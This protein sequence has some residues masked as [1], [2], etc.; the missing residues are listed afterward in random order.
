MSSLPESLM[1]FR[2]ELENAI[3]LE[4]ARQRKG[5]RRR[6]LLAVA[7]AGLVV[8][9]ASASAFGTVRDFFFGA[10]RSVES[11]AP[12]WSPD[13]RRIAFVSTTCAP[14]RSGCAGPSEIVVVGLDGSTQ[15]KLSQEPVRTGLGSPPVL[16]PNWRKIAFVR[17]RGLYRKY[18][19]G[20][21]LHYSDIV[22]MNVDG[23][24][25]RLL[26]RR[27]F[28]SDPVWSPDGNKVAFVRSRGNNTEVYVANADGSGRR[29]LAHAVS[30]VPNPYGVNKGR[31]PSPAWSPDGQ[32]I[33]FMSNRG[34]NED[35][36]VVNVDGAGMVNV[37]QSRGTD[38]TPVWSPDGRRIAFRSDRDGNGEVYA[39]NADGSG[40]QRLTRNP[41]SDGGPVWSPDGRKILFERFRH[42]NSDI[43]VMNRDGSGQRNLTP[44]VRP[45]RIA[46][47]SSPAWSPAGRLIAFVSERD[48]TRKVYVMT[49]AGGES[50]ALGEFVD[51][52][53]PVG[54][55]SRSAGDVRFSLSVPKTSPL[56][57]NG[58]L[59]PRFLARSFLIRRSLVRGQAA[60]VMIY[61]TALPGGRQVAPC[62]Q[63]LSPA[64]ARSSI[65]DLAATLAK[66]PGSELVEAPTRVT[67]GG[68]PARYVELVVREDRGCNPGFFFT[69]RDQ[70]WGALWGGTEPGDR[71]RAWIVGVDGRR[72]FFVAETKEGFNHPLRPPPSKSD[73]QRVGREITKIVESIRFE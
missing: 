10:R 22:V 50:G 5:R 63:L 40:L 56:W 13:G 52:F 2:T 30:Y 61:W 73:L 17:D 55:I 44:D 46:R 15:R 16:S 60:E 70:M 59:G 32:R 11:G 8:T 62:S 54:R 53:F 1:Q 69:W 29:R 19:D 65:D 12:M 51:E 68:R 23:S 34:G 9:V 35:I 39:M 6:R 27:A 71:I 58:P 18:P 64:L 3:G 14:H 4:L 20:T 38:R 66:A 37:T 48:N 24:R 31:S 67:L 26:T 36:F 41:A 49:A 42:G 28:Y 43:W 47:D 21:S 45:A 33:A 7:A 25:Q 72:L 57:E